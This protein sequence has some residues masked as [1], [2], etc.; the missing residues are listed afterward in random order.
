LDNWAIRTEIGERLQTML[1]VD[2]SM[3]PI[4]IEKSSEKTSPI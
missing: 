2:C 4:E 1:R 3:L